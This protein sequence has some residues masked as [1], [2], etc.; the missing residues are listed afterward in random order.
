MYVFLFKLV[1]TNSIPFFIVVMIPKDV[2][3]TVSISVVSSVVLLGNSDEDIVASDDVNDVENVDVSE[4]DDKLTVV[5]RSVVEMASV[6]EM[7]SV[8]KIPSVVEM[9]SVIVIF[10]KKSVTTVLSESM[11][12]TSIVVDSTDDVDVLLCSVEFSALVENR[13]V[14][15]SLIDFV[16][17][18][19]SSV[20]ID[21]ELESIDASVLI[22]TVENNP[23]DSKFVVDSNVE[24]WSV[25]ERIGLSIELSWLI[26]ICTS[27]ISTSL[28]FLFGGDFVVV[29]EVFGEENVSFISIVVSFSVSM[30]SVV[31]NVNSSVFVGI[32][33]LTVEMLSSSVWE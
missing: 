33:K 15:L 2:D 10:V 24:D 29:K 19:I 1:K 26:V 28:F 25:V 23:V 18:Y 4:L 22:T 30:N 27:E 8:V 13:G 32:S 20:V 14:V 31:I 21:G 12:D 16:S 11:E 17:S 6:V 5:I 3:S 7:T 9:A